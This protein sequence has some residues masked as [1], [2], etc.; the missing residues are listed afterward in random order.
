MMVS[1]AGGGDQ[2]RAIADLVICCSCV[3][4]S[5]GR[6]KRQARRLS[7]QANNDGENGAEQ[8]RMRGSVVLGSK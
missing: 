3:P 7:G 8:V 6:M 2:Q 5:V 1:N 4:V